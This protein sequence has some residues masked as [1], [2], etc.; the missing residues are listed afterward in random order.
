M[1]KGGSQDRDDIGYEFFVRECCQEMR[2]E[3]MFLSHLF[4]WLWL[5][6]G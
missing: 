1:V 4:R 5:A 6:R 3:S 2:M